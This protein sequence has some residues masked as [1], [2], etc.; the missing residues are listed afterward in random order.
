VLVQLPPNLHAA[1]ERLDETLRAFPRSVRVAVEP[2]HASWWTDD[3]RRVL[4][5]HNAA[6]CLADRGSRMVTPQWRTADWGYVRWHYGRATPRSCYG[7]S[8]LAH[9]VER[10]ASEWGA[11]A[12]VYAYFNN[13]GEGCAV[14]DA[15][16]F[17]GLA[18]ARGLHP[19]RVPA[20]SE[21][22]VG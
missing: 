3:V 8:A 12:D 6:L 14:R 7:R 22:P 10:I 11:G 5:R 20:R 19:T 17:A 13:D 15:V 9:W 4:E 21:A 18:S 16:V 1:P 2:R